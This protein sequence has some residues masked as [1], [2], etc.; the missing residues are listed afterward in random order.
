MSQKRAT[1]FGKNS[2][3]SALWLK[4]AAYSYLRGILE[5]LGTK[6]MPAHEL[7]QLRQLGVGRKIGIELEAGL[8]VIALEGV[9]RRSISR[10]K[11]A[12]AEMVSKRYDRDLILSKVDA[13]QEKQRL[14]D[15]FYYI[16]RIVCNILDADEA[17]VVAYPKIVQIALDLSLDANQVEKLR[18]NL[19]REAAAALKK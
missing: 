14:A 9:T 10:A 4:A 5:M 2:I 7:E 3:I 1:D 11:K 16:G 19:F 17:A 13:L 8:D 6:A 18:R 12:L 15:A